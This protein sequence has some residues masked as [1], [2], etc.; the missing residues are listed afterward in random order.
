MYRNQQWFCA[1]WLLHC[2]M[3]GAV[4]RNVENKFV[5]MAIVGMYAVL[6]ALLAI[7]K[8]WKGSD[9]W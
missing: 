4:W 1:L 2:Y 7:F 9:T 3:F 6:L 8:P 5:A